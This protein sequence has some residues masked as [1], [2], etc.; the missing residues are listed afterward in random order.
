VPVFVQFFG[1]AVEYAD[2]A[3]ERQ[4][5]WNLFRCPGKTCNAKCDCQQGKD[6]SVESNSKS[7]FHH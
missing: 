4:F 7:A 5:R 2:V 3:D 1:F 6:E